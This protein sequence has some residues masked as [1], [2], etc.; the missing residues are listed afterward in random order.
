MEGIFNRV[1]V[2]LP[3]QLDRGGRSSPLKQV[4]DARGDGGSGQETARERNGTETVYGVLGG[5][6]RRGSKRMHRAGVDDVNVVSEGWTIYGL[7]LL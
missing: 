6:R 4:R 1:T 2:S 5:E 7:S 3:M